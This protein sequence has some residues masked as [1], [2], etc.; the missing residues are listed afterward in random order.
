[1]VGAVDLEEEMSPP[2]VLLLMGSVPERINDLVFGMD[3]TKLRYR[4]GPAF[5]TLGGLISHMLDSGTKVDALQIG[6]AH[7]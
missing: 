5:P 1:M 6:R 7:V 3:E 4:H 2:D